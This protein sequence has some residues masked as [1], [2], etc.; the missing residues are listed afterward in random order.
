MDELLVIGESR[1]NFQA[2]K[3]DFSRPPPRSCKNTECSAGNPKGS[4]E[5]HWKISSY[6]CGCDTRSSH[7]EAT[8]KTQEL[9]SQDNDFIEIDGS[10]GKMS[11]QKP[12]V[13]ERSVAQMEWPVLP[14]R[15]T[16]DGCLH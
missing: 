6:V 4:I 14:P 15:E 1:D 16:R 11:V 8:P 7:T 5:L 13:L 10:L 9:L 12:S 3:V 2:E